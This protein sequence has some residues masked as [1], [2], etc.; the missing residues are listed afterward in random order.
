M[1]FLIFLRKIILIYLIG[2]LSLGVIYIIVPPISTLMIARLATL[3]GFSRDS[4]SIDEVSPQLL[5]A[6]IRAEDSKFCQHYG[7]DWGSMADAIE[8][9]D[10]RSRGA[11][12]IPMQVA[13]NLFLWPHHSY[14]R[15]AIEIP[16]AMYLN[17]IWSKSRMMEV[18]LSV[19]E[20][21]DGIFG[22]EAA[23]QKYFHK[24][25]KQLN[26]TESAMLAAMLPSPL[27]YNPNRTSGY[28]VSYANNIQKWANAGVDI[29]CVKK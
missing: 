12:T 23:A 24:S 26:A 9:K 10:G 19:A 13:K 8:N 7:I 11:S 17:A 3:Q 22:V 20:W 28:Y 5:R 6:V 18:Y 27:R 1:R 4:I 2:V 29:S 16:I 25:A 21:G 14:L 15:K